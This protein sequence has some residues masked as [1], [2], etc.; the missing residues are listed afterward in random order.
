[1]WIRR[2]P[3]EVP[4][5]VSLDAFMHHNRPLAHG[6]VVPLVVTNGAA[7]DADIALSRVTWEVLVPTR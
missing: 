7:I 1:M 2:G 4:V 6:G 5:C 3:N